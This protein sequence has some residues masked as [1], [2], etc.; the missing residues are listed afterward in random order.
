[1]DPPSGLSRRGLIGGVGAVVAASLVADVAYGARPAAAATVWWFP[2]ATA[3][4][5]SS[6]YGWRKHPV[7]GVRTFHDGVDIEANKL[8][9]VYAMRD[10]TVNFAGLHGATVSEGFGNYVRIQ[11]ADGYETGY[12]HLQYIDVSNGQS[13]QAGTLIGRSGSTGVSTGPH[14]H[15]LMHQNGSSVDP[16]A[17]LNAAPLATG[18]A[19]PI[20]VPT[21]EE[22]DDMANVITVS[23]PDGSTGQV[24]WSVNLGDNTKAR[25]YNGTQLTFRRNIGIPEYSNQPPQTLQGYRELPTT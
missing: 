1:M 2:L 15:L 11:H 19:Q 17:I 9:P 10:G 23:V 4:A 3:K 5:Y 16:T 24:W 21:N 7:T 25:I 8:T 12:G 22:E 6:G 18:T 13:V 20:D 14:L